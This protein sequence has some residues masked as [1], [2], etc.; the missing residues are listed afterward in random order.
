MR[1]LA[2]DDGK[3]VLWGKSRRRV[4]DGGTAVAPRGVRSIELEN[5]KMRGETQ[6]AVG[7][8]DDRDGA[9]LAVGIAPICQALAIVGR[10]GVGEDAQDLAGGAGFCSAGAPAESP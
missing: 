3:D 10:Y 8:L 7:A 5:V 1:L 9:A 2:L 6:V 4:E